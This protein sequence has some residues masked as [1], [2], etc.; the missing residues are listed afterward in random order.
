MISKLLRFIY[1][2]L[3]RFR[4]SEH[5]PSYEGRRR[6]IL[7]MGVSED[8]GQEVGQFNLLMSIVF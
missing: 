8:I 4:T 5:Q 6:V 3:K 1:I 2:Y 7:H